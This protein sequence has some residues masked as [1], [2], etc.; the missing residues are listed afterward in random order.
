MPWPSRSACRESRTVHA[1]RPEQL[2]AVR[3]QRQPRPL[4]DRERRREVARPAATL[5][6][7]QA[8]PHD[9]AVDVLRGE[10]GQGAGVERVPGPV[11]GDD[12]R[13]AEAGVPLRDSTASSTRSV[14][15]VTPPNGRRT[16]RVH[17]DLQ[18]APAVADV[19]LGGLAHQAAYVVLGAQHGP[20]DVVEPLEAEP[21]LLVRGREPRRPLRDQRVRQRDAVTCAS[22]SRVSCR[23]DP[24]KCRCR[25]ALGSACRSR[26]PAVVR[27]TTQA[28]SF[29]R[30]VIP[31][32]MSLSLR[33]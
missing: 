29:W 18:P 13:H 22:S 25:C 9:P 17:L 15:A 5:V 4:R 12:Y 6:V 7:G 32:T 21:A 16:A 28:N 19:V 1:V 26:P 23:I 27:A 11:G 24:V 14:N 30:R 31:S 2:A 3:D 10:P 8:E 33:A 20:G